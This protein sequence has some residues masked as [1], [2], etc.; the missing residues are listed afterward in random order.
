MLCE[1]CNKNKANIHLIK[2][3]KGKRTGRWLCEKCA[4][5]FGELQL[6]ELLKDDNTSTIDMLNDIFD[7]DNNIE[8]IVCKACGTT[9][10]RFMDKGLLGCSKCYKYFGIHLDLKI[11]DIQGEN[12]HKGKIPERAGK[13]IRKNKN[14]QTL[15]EELRKAIVIEDYEEAAVIRDKIKILE[16]ELNGGL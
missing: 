4:R 2:V 5:E 8:E 12:R 15:K 9:Y 3:I 7:N 6:T 1:R 14:L 11:K 13:T 10:K 16:K